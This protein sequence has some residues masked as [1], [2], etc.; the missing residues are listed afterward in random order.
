MYADWALTNL[1]QQARITHT[2]I[3]RYAY[4]YST[5][6]AISTIN[7]HNHRHRVTWSRDTSS[8]L[9]V[10]LQRIATLH[11]DEDDDG[12]SLLVK[13]QQITNANVGKNT[14]NESYTEVNNYKKWICNVVSIYTYRPICTNT[15][16]AVLFQAASTASEMTYTVS[17]GALNS[18]PTPT[19]SQ[20]ASASCQYYD[21]FTAHKL[22]WKKLK[23]GYWTKLNWTSLQ[24]V[25][26][27]ETHLFRT[28]VEFSSV[29][30]VLWTHLHLHAHPFDI[31]LLRRRQ[32]TLSV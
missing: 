22:D 32:R 20:A 13:K 29:R 28:G 21:V 24:Q 5:Q 30:V 10:W 7:N 25:D 31:L 4:P 15:T 1:P 9:D 26:P 12:I 8:L 14:K 16:Q 23:L 3:T 18:T 2:T 27:V 11:H 6:L 17:S 19:P